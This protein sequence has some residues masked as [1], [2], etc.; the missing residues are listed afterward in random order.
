MARAGV[1]KG[2]FFTI[3]LRG[4]LI[5]VKGFIYPPLDLTHLPS[6]SSLSLK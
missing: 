1:L 6:A 2:G 3:L 4:Y 5:L